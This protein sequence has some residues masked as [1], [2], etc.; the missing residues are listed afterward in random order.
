MV[1]P[2]TA[3]I[4][5]FFLL[6]LSATC[7]QLTWNLDR[8]SVPSSDHIEQSRYNVLF[9]MTEDMR[10]ELSAY[11]RGHV[12]APNIARIAAKG[13]VFELALAQVAVCA[14]SRS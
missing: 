2:C 7:S 6:F 1:F 4:V 5:T 12:I 3:I 10:P 11:G 8:S 9:V 13:V 14:P